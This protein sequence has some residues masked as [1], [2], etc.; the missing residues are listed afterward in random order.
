MTHW[1]LVLPIALSVDFPPPLD[2]GSLNL[3]GINIAPAMLEYKFR[4][5]P[6]FGKKRFKCLKQGYPLFSLTRDLYE[7]VIEDEFYRVD[8]NDLALFVTAMGFHPTK[9]YQSMLESL[10]DWEIAILFKSPFSGA[11]S[12]LCIYL[13]GQK[14]FE[15]CSKPKREKVYFDYT[16]G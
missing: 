15:K 11:V 3:D 4:T 2:L 9:H 16:S 10:Q 14:T 6:H 12:S 5:H 8:E 1:A 13:V 7:H